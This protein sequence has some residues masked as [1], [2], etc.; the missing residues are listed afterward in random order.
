LKLYEMQLYE[1]K[2][3]EMLLRREECLWAVYM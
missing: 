1:S 2:L 3:Y